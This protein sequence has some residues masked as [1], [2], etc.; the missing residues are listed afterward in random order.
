MRILSSIMRA[1]KR[2]R[3]YAIGTETNYR[4]FNSHTE[5]QSHTEF[6]FNI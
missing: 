3:G 1:G 6:Y 5:T 2:K 4:L